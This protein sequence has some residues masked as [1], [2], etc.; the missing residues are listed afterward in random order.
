MSSNSTLALSTPNRRRRVRHK[1]QTPAYASFNS[2]PQQ[3]KL[4][5][6]EIVDISEDGMAIQC[7]SPLEIKTHL[8]LCL[9]LA[10]CADQIYTTGQVIWSDDS[11]RAGLRFS[12]L[13][14][15]A[16]ARLREWLFV[17]VMAGVAN[18]ETEI[19]ALADAVP[20]RPNYTDTLAAVSVV[21]RQVESLGSDLVAALRTIAD[22]TLELV[23]ASGAAIALAEKDPD[24][25][26]CRASAGNDAP[27]IGA[28]LQVGSGFSGEC[29]K[30]GRLLRCDDSETDA[31]VDRDSCR[32]L[33]IR[34][35]LAA[36]VRT[37]GKS[38][39]L[40]EAFAAEPNA[41]SEIDG[42]VLQRFADT[43]LAAVNRAGGSENSGSGSSSAPGSVLFAS[44]NNEDEKANDKSHEERKGISAISLPRAHLIILACAAGTIFLALG[45]HLAPWVQ[46]EATPWIAAKIHSRANA[47]LPTVLAS[48]PPGKT[49]AVSPE[50][51]AID[52]ANFDQLTQMAQKGD[53]VAQNALGLRYATG[54]GIKL[55]ELE[56]V[57]WFTK[58]A[59]QGNVPAQS[60]LGSIYFSG[61]GV[62]ADPNRAYFWMVVARL[63]GDEASKTLSPFV[64]ARLTRAQVTAIELDADHW[65]QQHRT[66]KPPAGQLKAR[67]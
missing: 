6:H 11:G 52:S 21:Q 47:H 60:K 40:I 43:V 38:I 53:P 32:A 16:L 3:T 65:L 8:D 17:N 36:P 48:S 37:E 42:R 51:A 9:D 45:Y 25:M 12:D 54:D 49:N 1:I 56:A 13:A 50:T 61:R 35:I 66:D 34:S 4:D 33:G 30:T 39:G 10:D 67:N 63:S 58:A 55:N 57:R 5:L 23:R 7:H 15:D 29:V 27:P 62:P 14:P 22:R 26:V 18:G 28:R 24:F 59:E 44:I 41:F 19:D 64:R 31:R 20:P 2:D 46:S